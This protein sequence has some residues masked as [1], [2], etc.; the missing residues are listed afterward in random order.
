[1]RAL[2][3]ATLDE[4]E[5]AGVQVSGAVPLE[6]IQ[7]FLPAETAWLSISAYKTARSPV[8]LAETVCKFARLPSK[9]E[10]AR[11]FS[12]SNSSWRNSALTPSM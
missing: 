2:R 9:P 11:H 6:K 10:S 1:M 5:Q 8:C 3:E 4:A 7:S 12:C